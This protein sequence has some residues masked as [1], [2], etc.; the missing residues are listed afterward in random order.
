MLP[1]KTAKVKNTIIS[2]L[3]L[4]NTTPDTYDLTF[5]MANPAAKTLAN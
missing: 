2:N 5:F 3:K 4:S 1:I